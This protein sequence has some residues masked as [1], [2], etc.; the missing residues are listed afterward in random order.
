MARHWTSSNSAKNR[1]LSATSLSL[2]VMML[3]RAVGRDAL[4]MPVDDKAATL[5]HHP[6][7]GSDGHGLSYLTYPIPYGCP[8]SMAKGGRASG[9]LGDAKAVTCNTYLI[10]ETR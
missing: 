8:S 10:K 1:V 9:R 2:V 6:E 5:P 7:D 4:E 3:T